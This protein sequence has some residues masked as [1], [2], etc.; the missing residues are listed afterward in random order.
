MLLENLEERDAAVRVDAGIRFACSK[1]HSM[2]AGDMG[3][4]TTEVGD[5]VVEGASA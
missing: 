2:R 5:L 3:Y 1:L 4:T